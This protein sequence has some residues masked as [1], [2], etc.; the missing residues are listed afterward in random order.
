[1]SPMRDEW[2]ERAVLILGGIQDKVWKH[3][4]MLLSIT[5]STSFVQCFATLVSQTIPPPDIH[6][7]VNTIPDV[8]VHTNDDEGFDTD[9]IMDEDEFDPPQTILPVRSKRKYSALLH[10]ACSRKRSNPQASHPKRRYSN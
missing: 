10:S 6:Q 7:L 1:M 2:R 5:I 8:A 9:D 4:L 3:I